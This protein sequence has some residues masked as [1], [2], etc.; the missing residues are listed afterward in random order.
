MSVKKNC[1]S[2][3]LRVFVLVAISLTGCATNKVMQE[4]LGK[5]TASQTP[6]RAVILRDG[7]VAIDYSYAKLLK[8]GVRTYYYKRAYYESNDFRH[9]KEEA[10]VP[11]NSTGGDL[12][13][14]IARYVEG[15]N[16]DKEKGDWTLLKIATE[17][18]YK[19]PPIQEQ[20]PASVC[21][22]ITNHASNIDYYRGHG[23]HAFI[24]CNEEKNQFFTTTVVK[25]RYEDK[26]EWWFYPAKLLYVPAVVFDVVTSPIQ[27]VILIYV[28]NTWHMGQ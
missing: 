16:P 27:L 3:I 1:L 6:E 22:K 9:A 21:M 23:A 10:G 25:F 4:E 17:D 8:R 13:H 5:Y 24:I 20:D 7:R 28:A 19:L 15:A 14:L 12:E 26:Y 2:S 18:E 11:L